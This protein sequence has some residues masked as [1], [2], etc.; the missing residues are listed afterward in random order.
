MRHA[1]ANE[2]RE[3]KGDH[4]VSEYILG[5]GSNG[6]H[7]CFVPIPSVGAYADGLIRRAMIV[8]KDLEVGKVLEKR[9]ARADV[10]LTEKNQGR[11]VGF[12]R[13]LKEEPYFRKFTSASKIWI[14]VSPL[15]LH[16]HDYRRGKFSLI[17]TQGLIL[18]ALRKSGYAAE[19]VER[20][21]FQKAPLFPR[22]AHV[23]EY[24][25]PNHL[26][27]WPR[28][29]VGVEFRDSVAGP[30]LASIGQHYGFGLFIATGSGFS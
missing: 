26:A 23:S 7:I 22:V 12:L 18:Q 20:M 27:R 29:H 17:K 4:W 9:L 13:V 25:I 21:W 10:A 1:M 3:D 15:I 19:N 30:V 14:T 28:Y 5:H 11:V 24:G 6:D 16:G 2:L 8:G